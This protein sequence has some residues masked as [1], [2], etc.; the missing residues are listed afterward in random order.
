[1]V[2]CPK[3]T[4]VTNHREQKEEPPKAFV[5]NRRKTIRGATQT[6]FINNLDGTVS[7]TS[8]NKTFAF[9]TGTS[10]SCINLTQNFSFILEATLRKLP[11]TLSRGD[12]STRLAIAS[13][14]ILIFVKAPV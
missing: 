11:Y 8:R 10:T 2:Y 1:M 5:N 3:R 4:S 12:P 7:L 14:A 6:L 13:L 9:R